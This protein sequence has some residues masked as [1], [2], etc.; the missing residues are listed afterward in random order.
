MCREGKYIYLM[1]QQAVEAVMTAIVAPSMALGEKW[2]FS[3]EQRG[4]TISPWTPDS[5]PVLMA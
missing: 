1:P 2:G 5:I 3:W 4:L